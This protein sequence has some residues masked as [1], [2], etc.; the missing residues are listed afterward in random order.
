MS[1][2][3]RKT[4]GEVV[5]IVEDGGI[6]LSTG[7]YLIGRSYVGYGEYIFDNFIRLMENFSNSNPPA[8]PLEGQ[9]WYDSSSKLLKVWK[10][11]AAVGS[12][13]RLID[14][15]DV[16]P[17]IGQTL[18]WDGNAWKPG[19]ILGGVGKIVAGDNISISP[20]NGLGNVTI[21]STSISNGTGGFDFGDFRKTLTTPI[22]YLID[23]V[24]IDFGTF[25][26]PAELSMDLGTF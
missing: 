4:S 3:I 19:T 15:L 1:Y 11:E 9:I 13:T 24:G 22:S 16:E 6:D 25:M 5:T 21:S 26:N 17:T 2:I 10:I 20:T 18:V 14:V 12:W 23:A 8:N 7:I